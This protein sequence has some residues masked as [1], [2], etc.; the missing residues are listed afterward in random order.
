MDNFVIGNM[1]WNG[2]LVFAL[3]WFIKRTIS[4]S[5]KKADTNSEDIKANAKEARNETKEAAGILDN[6]IEGIYIEL[7]TA[8]GR[9]AKLEG[10][11]HDQV[12]LC[13]TRNERK[14]NE[15]RRTVCGDII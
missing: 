5:D 10:A 3:G 2:G 14:G 12:T 6:K 7:K 15:E 13:K 4:Q 1:I 11:I 9:T 8:N